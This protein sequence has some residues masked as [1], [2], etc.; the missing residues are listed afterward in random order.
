MGFRQAVLE[1]A[2]SLKCFLV[3]SALSRRL[4]PQPRAQKTD[5]RRAG[6]TGLVAMPAER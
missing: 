4:G 5:L 6:R 1:V 3:S 2:S